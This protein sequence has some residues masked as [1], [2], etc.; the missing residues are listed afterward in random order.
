MKILKIELQNIN[1]LTSDKPIEIDFEGEQFCDVGL[2]A[3]TGATGAGKTTILDAITIALYNQV[4]RFQKSNIKA[5][6]RDV[7]S[8]GAGE[9]LARVTFENKEARF[10]AQWSMRIIG[11]NGKPLSTPDE[12]VRL[13][14]LTTARIIAEKKQEFKQK[15]IE[16]TQLSYEQ[17]LRSVMLAQGEFAAFLSASAK[18]KGTLLEQITGEEIYKKIGEAIINRRGEEYKI[19]EGIKAKINTEDLLPVDTFQA[20]KKEEEVLSEQLKQIAPETK[21]LEEILQWY[22]KEEQLKQQAETLILKQKTLQEN[23]IKY[24][25]ELKKLES[26][27]EAL[28]YKKALEDIQRLEEQLV[29][30]RKEYGVLK[31]VVDK[32]NSDHKTFETVAVDTEKKYEVAIATQNQWLPKLEKV[33]ALDTQIKTI[34]QQQQEIKTVL[35]TVEKEKIAFEHTI[36]EKQKQHE[37]EQK[38][39]EELQRYLEDHKTVLLY[40]KEISNWNAAL[41]LRKQQILQIKEQE[42]LIKQKDTEVFK[43]QTQ[44]QKHEKQIKSER[45]LLTVRQQ[46]IAAINEKL[47]DNDLEVLLASQQKL[48]KEQEVYKQA[49]QVSDEYVTTYKQFEALTKENKTLLERLEATSKHIKSLKGE[50]DKAVVAVNDAEKILKLELAV[51]NYEEERKKLVADEACP[52]CGS[53][54]HPYVSQYDNLNVSKT[55]EEFKT[56]QQHLQQLE[57]EL[58]KQEIAAVALDTSYKNKNAQQLELESKIKELQTSFAILELTYTINET[59]KLQE[60]VTQ[61]IS[62]YQETATLI[63]QTQQ[64]I[65]TKERNQTLFAKE[66]EKVVAIEQKITELKTQCELFIAEIQER[67]EKKDELVEQV[68]LKTNELQE[69]LAL[70]QLQ[71]PQQVDDI[72]RFIHNLQANV[73]AYSTKEKQVIQLEN[74]RGKLDLAIQNLEQQRIEKTKIYTQHK[75]QDQEFITSLKRF[76]VERN[77]ILPQEYTTVQK[78][79]ELQTVIEQTKINAEKSKL[80]L[81]ET[82]KELAAQ[83][84]TQ[85]RLQKEGT[86][87]KDKVTEAT[88]ELSSKLKQTSFETIDKLK[89]NLLD[90]TLEKEYNIL[91]RQFEDE[92]LKL[93]TQQE[94]CESDIKKQEAARKFE[95]THEE[96]KA[97]YETIAERRNEMLKQVGAIKE[98]FELDQKIKQ[99]NETVVAEIKQQELHVLKW[100][101]LL[102]TIGGSKDAFNTYVQRLTL[103]NLIHLANLHLFNLNKRYSLQMNET[104]KKGEELNFMLIDHYQAN[105][106]R[107]VDTCSGGEKFLISLSLALGLSDLS[108]NNVSIGSL[109]IDEG[110]GTLDTNTL[111][112]VI[113]TLETLQ[114]QGKMIGIISHVENLKERIPTQIQVLKKNNGVSEVRIR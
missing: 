15:I 37:S 34:V 3:I 17:F 28:P 106:S 73:T 64:M 27:E 88:T 75:E 4:P 77:E 18:E 31:Q 60:I 30:R 47:K 113:A 89:F 21:K 97:V 53:T 83:K 101:R 105:E 109:F 103:Q 71:I 95:T 110:F 55:E 108:S 8:Y 111:E 24:N 46:D 69:E 80:R 44:L 57:Q 74:N 76:S 36:K 6:L 94:Q 51:K 38:S 81:Q 104:Y 33:T 43:Y 91:K 42:L 79:Q 22:V 100:T 90:V 29:E 48:Q 67:K 41:Q 39:I 16:I 93:K 12:K 7:V 92:S 40:E 54:T 62:K 19:L 26:H 25:Q 112:T 2:Y 66:Q 11:K 10:E 9:A 52:L 114:E 45:E 1:S 99:R 35:T 84:E 56:R 87:L 63:N 13:K 32:L 50:I 68:E 5:T 14:N 23:K 59:I 82:Q 58:K 107:L 49:V 78:R 70:Y 102:Q 85:E 61:T 86:I 98:K 65:T 96:A 20:L 72:S